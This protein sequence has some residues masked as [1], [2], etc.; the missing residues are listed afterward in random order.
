HHHPFEKYS[1]QDYRNFSTFFSRVGTKN[2]Q[3]F[4]LFGRESVVVVR[5]TG[6]VK[7][8]PLDGDALTHPLD[9]RI[10]LANWLTSP[11]NEYFAKNV[12][13]RY[14]AYL[15]GRGLVE[16]IDDLRETNPPTNVA[17]MDALAKHF[18]KSGYDLKQLIRAIMVS[19]LYQ[20]SSQPTKSNASDRRFYSHFQVKRIAAEP[21][22]DAIDVATGVQTKFKNLPLGTRATDLPDAE[23]P[24]YF[25]STFGKP[26]RASVC[27]CER[28]PDEN[29]SQALHTLNGDTLVKKI[30]DRNGR[31]A[32]LLKAKTPH[33]DI[34][35][36]L[37]LA[38]L[39]RPPSQ[40]EQAACRKLLNEGPSPKEFYED[41]LWALLNS[42][43]F[44]FVR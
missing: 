31:V 15:L 34:V 33:E 4:G 14:V 10:P 41:L 23:Y 13:N 39:N 44:L 6:N 21:L 2:S 5:P 8:R 20:L 3:E 18:V 37:Y 38:A 35:K 12:V 7:A 25:L 42:K 29:L 27:E 36:R 32:R 17:L 22:L 11:K 9:L 19:R 28:M 40:K 1:Q 24:N 26:K 16:P 30:A 43:Q